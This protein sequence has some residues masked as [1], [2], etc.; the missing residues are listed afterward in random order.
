MQRCIEL[1]TDVTASMRIQ[2]HSFCIFLD[3]YFK[4][5]LIQFNMLGISMKTQNL[6]KETEISCL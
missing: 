2:N 4:K 1:L 6:D 5:Y 3:I